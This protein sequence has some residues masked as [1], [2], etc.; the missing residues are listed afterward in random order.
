MD[1]ETA[2]ATPIEELRAI[3]G[4]CPSCEREAS[5]LDMI[6]PE[7]NPPGPI[8]EAELRRILD[9]RRAM[10]ADPARAGMARAI[11]AMRFVC[12]P[13]AARLAMASDS[14]RRAEAAAALKRDVYRRGEMPLAALRSTFRVADPAICALNPSAWRIASEWPPRNLWIA[15][16]KGTGKT[17]LAECILNAAI[18]RNVTAMESLAHSISEAG[19]AA[20]GDKRRFVHRHASAGLLL[21]DDIDK[22]LWG[23]LG[24][25]VLWRIIDGRH[26]ARLATVVTA[27]FTGNETKRAWADRFAQNLSIVDSM[28]DRLLG[29]TGIRMQGESLRASGG[30][31]TEQSAPPTV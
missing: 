29:C 12:G 9:N 1:S 4:P 7:A 16:P 23:G 27:Q 28:F 8:K 6:D 10:L 19:G 25:E 26:R 20:E 18:E 3:I 21:I 15:G 30:K 2:Y 14:Q 13:C 31:N 17:F 11:D 22:P 5:M 24:L